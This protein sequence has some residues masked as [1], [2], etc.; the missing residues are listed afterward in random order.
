VLVAKLANIKAG[1]KSLLGELAF[2]PCFN[3]M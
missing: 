3:A 1:R 2:P